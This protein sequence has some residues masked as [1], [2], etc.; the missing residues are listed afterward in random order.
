M[1]L[2]I[3]QFRLRLRVQIIPVAVQLHP[4][5]LMKSTPVMCWK[6]LGYT[7]GVDRVGMRGP[8]SRRFKSMGRHSGFWEY[9]LQFPICS[10]S[11]GICFELNNTAISG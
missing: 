11:E 5:I 7:P 2:A 1:W 10:T 9:I 4:T 3:S 6:S 8:A